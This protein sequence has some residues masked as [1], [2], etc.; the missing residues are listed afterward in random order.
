MNKY[1][2]IPV[3]TR[4]ISIDG[5]VLFDMLGNVDNELYVRELQRVNLTYENPLCKYLQESGYIDRFNSKTKML[6][7]KKKIPE[8]LLIVRND[9]KIYE[10]F[11]EKEIECESDAYLEAF[12]VKSMDVKKCIGNG[13]LYAKRV[14]KFIKLGNKKKKV[15]FKRKDSVKL[16]K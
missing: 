10:F 11:S 2:L 12:R 8:K 15:F 4:E 9:N 7:K 16:S 14:L 5:N 13:N 1:Y 6:Y 3:T